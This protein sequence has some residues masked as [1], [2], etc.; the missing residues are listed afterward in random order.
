MRSFVLDDDFF[1][2]SEPGTIIRSITETNT[3]PRL[4]V[5]GGAFPER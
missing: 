3:E 4:I 2:N 1:D 5:F